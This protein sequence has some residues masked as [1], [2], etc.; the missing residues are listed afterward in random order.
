MSQ[1]LVAI[2]LLLSGFVL[3]LTARAAAPATCAEAVYTELGREE[4][5]YRSVIFG[6]AK[7]EAL[8]IS[9]TLTDK[10]G[11]R[12]LKTKENEW[13]STD[14]GYQGTTWRD[15]FM[16]EQ[17]D[18]PA[19]R[20]ILEVRQA[21][22]SELIPSV[23]QAVRASQCRMYAVC[24]AARAS[25]SAKDD[26]EEVTVQP[27]GCIEFELPVMDACRTSELSSFNQGGCIS[28]VQTIIDRETRMLELLFAYDASYRTL[29]QFAG[30]FEG[31]L[32]DFRFPLLQPLWQMV[33]TL[34]QLDNLPCFLAECNE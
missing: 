30:T 15:E 12:W 5:L 16:E 21:L 22:S 11:N 3:P 26:E 29:M 17:R 9:S 14:A 33:R 32:S 13:R 8:P 1:R 31:F 6:L 10:K 28:Q 4:R 18:V 20:G 24:D 7:S 2:G 34:G 27:D 25:D 23:L 19:R